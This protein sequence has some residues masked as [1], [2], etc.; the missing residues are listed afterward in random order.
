MRMPERVNA[1]WLATLGNE[2]L[3]EAE[4]KLHTEF[5]AQE[6]REKKRAGD[7]YVML[8]GPE[9]LV[10]AW[11]RWLMVNNEATARGM[12]LHRRPSA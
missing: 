5:S 3:A 2:Q 10:N 1:A 6:T 11:H 12:N 4:A 8:R 7:R 9:S